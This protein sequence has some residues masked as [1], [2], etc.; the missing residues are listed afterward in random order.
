MSG[1]IR[2]EEKARLVHGSVRC[3]QVFLTNRL[4]LSLDRKWTRVRANRAGDFLTCSHSAR[5]WTRHG[6]SWSESRRQLHIQDTVARSFVCGLR[7][8]DTVLPL[9][10]RPTGG[11]NRARAACIPPLVPRLNDAGPSQ[12]NVPTCSGVRVDTTTSKVLVHAFVQCHR[13]RP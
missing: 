12:R 5:S 8:R 7:W 1:S 10:T 9:R 4:G 3:R 2:K 11:T 6:K 13:S